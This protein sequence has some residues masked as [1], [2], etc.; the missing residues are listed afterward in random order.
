[1]NIRQFSGIT[2]IGLSLSAGAMAGAGHKT[3]K[4][5]EKLNLDAER[6]AQVEEI[7]NDYY[8]GK[9]ALRDEKKA[10]LKEVLTDEEMDQLK[11]MHERKREKMHKDY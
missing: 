1:M 11:A 5:A 6:A 9:K 2:I 7:M 8:E 10:R 3:D 4:I